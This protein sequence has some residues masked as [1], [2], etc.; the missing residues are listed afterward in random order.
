MGERRRCRRDPVRRRHER[1][2]R[3]GGRASTGRPVSL[4]LSALD[5]VLEVDHVSSAARIQAG[6][7]GPGARGPAPRARADPAPLPAVVRVLHARRLDRHARGRPLRHRSTRTSTTWSSRCARSR[8][9]GV[10]ESRRLPG[11]GAGPSPDRMLIGSE[12][13]LGV[14]TEA[15]VRV[16]PRPQFKASATVH[17]DSFE[18]GAEAVRAD[19]AVGALPDQLPPARRGRGPADRRLRPARC[20]CS[21]SSRPTTRSTRGWRA[22]LEICDREPT[23]DR[24]GRRRRLAQRLPRD[25]LPARHVDPGRRAQR[26][27][28]DR[29]HLGQ[30]RRPARGGPLARSRT[31][32]A[33]SRT[34]TRT[35]RRPYF[36]VVE[37]ARRGSELEQ[38]DEI[39]ARGVRRR[40]GGRGDD[41]PPP[42]RGEGPPS[43]VRPAAA[44]RL[45]RRRCARRR[46]RVDP[47]WILNPGTLISR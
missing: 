33:A 9:R 42:R 19:R 39:K 4:D 20:S 15:W 13:I 18:Q 27:V 41:H 43:V 17:F 11:S 47:G 12:G 28:R 25:A 21:G 40:A 24:L 26:H 46:P 14:I 35:G 36:T 31:P 16:R 5:R 3:G 8:P 44:R 30:A 7:L 1:G 38:W 23:V 2:R 10:W 22:P 37:P 6:V 29:D 32:P 45:S 34:S